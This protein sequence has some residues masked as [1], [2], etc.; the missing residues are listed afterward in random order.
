MKSSKRVIFNIRVS[1]K[2]SRSRIVP[3]RQG[4]FKVYLTKPAHDGLAN[5]QLV[6]LL[7]G[8]LE[9]KRYQVR[10]I[11]GLKARDKIVEITA[12]G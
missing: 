1:P 10:I 11:K 5:E 4:G 12:A 2:A 3:I 8:Y 7:A 9:V 6:E